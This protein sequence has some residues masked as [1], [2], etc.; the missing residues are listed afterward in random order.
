MFPRRRRQTDDGWREIEDISSDQY[1]TATQSADE[2]ASGVSAPPVCPKRKKEKEKTE[3][4]RAPPRTAIRY[5]TAR[6]VIFAALIPH[7]AA[8]CSRRRSGARAVLSQSLATN[9]THAACVSIS[10]SLTFSLP[11]PPEFLRIPL[12]FHRKPRQYK[13]SA[14]GGES[15][16]AKGRNGHALIFDERRN[17]CFSVRPSS[18]NFI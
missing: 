4:L 16:K 10:L 7:Q 17:H 8:S 1:N 12:P 3:H 15:A 2:N 5:K 6:Q 18:R 13:S 9:S 11:P 14:R